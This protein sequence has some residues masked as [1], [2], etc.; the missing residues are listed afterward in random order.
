[1]YAFNPF[2]KDL[3]E[4]QGKDL[5]ILRDVSEGWYVEYKKQSL[6]VK[7]LS[8]HLCAFANQYGGFMF[9]GVVEK[10]DG[11]RKADSFP[12]L[13]SED[14]SSLS[15]IVREAAI[16][17][18]SPP[19]YYEEHIIIG[20]C[21]DIE[22]LDDKCILIIGI[23]QGNNPPYIHSSGKIYRRLA[24]Q[25]KPEA[26]TDRHV[27]DLLWNKGNAFKKEINMF[28]RK[29]PKLPSAQSDSVWAF[30]HII[31]DINY[32]S[33]ERDIKLEQFKKLTFQQQDVKLEPF[34][35]MQSIFSK[36]HGFIARQV[37]N[38]DPG[39]ANLSLRW[40]HG[41]GARFDIPVNN[42]TIEQFY[43]NRM[44]YK[45][46][47]DFCSEAFRQGFR[48]I[49]IC[50]FSQLILGIVSLLNIYRHLRYETGDDRPAFA[51]F[52]LRNTFYKLPFV[53]SKKYI[54]RC[55]TN[56]IPV[57]QEEIIV[58]EDKPYIDNMISLA[59]ENKI[60]SKLSAD[61]NSKMFPYLYA[62]PI[63]YRILKYI[64]VLHEAEHLAVDAEM[65]GINKLR[66][67]K[68]GLINND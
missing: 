28:L 13:S 27:L 65:W 11:S 12:G 44:N 3:K 46:C 18:S 59:D 43:N 20:P 5:I 10:D 31:P 47:A 2:K 41:G 25:S 60:K 61:D 32:P 68:D 22:L 19:I 56:G 1:M 6:R 53:D 16:A 23:R 57:I 21:E 52:E 50:D 64:G 66:K 9:F 35:P 15:I 17:H 4:V 34:A 48:N 36:K 8:K 33:N 38:N 55:S 40:W 14:T 51:T 63:A 58:F 62:S 7:D 49:R 26:E 39:L 54:D 37:D 29:T 42:W 67:V 30:I 24:D 45:Y